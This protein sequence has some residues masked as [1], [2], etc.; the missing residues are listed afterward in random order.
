MDTGLSTREEAAAQR[1]KAAPDTPAEARPGARAS[2]RAAG[3]L[4]RVAAIA[5]NTFREAVRDRVLYN[6]VLFVLILTGGAVFLGEL[7]AAQETKIIIDMGLSAALL[8]G[9]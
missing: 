3:S 1:T 6:L 2:A 4:S 5:R 9:V 7:S 8:F